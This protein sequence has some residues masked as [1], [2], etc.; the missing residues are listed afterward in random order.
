MLPFK[1]NE[2][3]KIKCKGCEKDVDGESRPGLVSSG[4]YPL[5]LVCEVCGTLL[6]ERAT[7]REDWQSPS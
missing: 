7:E 5:V 2:Q 3:G 6:A 1:R 4:Q